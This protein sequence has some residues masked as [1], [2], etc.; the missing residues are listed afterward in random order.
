M[1]LAEQNLTQTLDFKQLVVDIRTW[2]KAL[3]FADLRITDTDVSAYVAAHKRCIDAELHGEMRYL[4]NNQDLRYHPEKLVPGSQ[5]ILC[6]RMDYLPQRVATD[7]QLQRSDQAYIA[8]YA[9]GRD[10]HKFM[11]KRLTRLAQRI[12]TRVGPYRYRA[13]VDSAPVL[14]RQL[15]E[16]SGLGWIGKNTLLL[17]KTAGSWFLL[18]EIY[19]DLPLPVDTPS[20]Q[21]CGQCTACLDVCPT[22]AFIAPWVLD[23]RKCIAYLTIEYKGSI[24]LELRPLMGN[25][26]FGCDDCQIFCPWTKFAARTTASEFQ[27]RHGLDSAGLVELFAWDEALFLANTAG[28]PIR[29]IGYECWLRNLAVGLG[30]APTRDDIVAALRR[31][32]D[33]PSALVREHVVWALQ[34]HGV[35]VV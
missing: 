29:R 19:T 16:K 8:R 32:L 14:E 22:N 15:A 33:H 1:H 20:Q 26:V 13:F 12:Q 28:S 31:R 5:R 17:N 24:P 21:H 6:V 2:S 3:G 4:E 11:R 30:N 23:A 34:Q 35:S 10:Y 7:A 25:R 9:L 18:G 27:P